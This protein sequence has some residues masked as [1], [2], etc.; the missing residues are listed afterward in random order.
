MERAIYAL[1]AAV[2]LH[3]GATYFGGGG[4]Y[5]M[6][7]ELVLDTR[8][9]NLWVLSADGSNPLEGARVHRVLMDL[10]GMEAARRARAVAAGR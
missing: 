8:T 1:A 5:S 6:S 10:P 9:G 4:R 2:L 3:A 7:D